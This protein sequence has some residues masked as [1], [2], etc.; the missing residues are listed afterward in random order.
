[1]RSFIPLI[2]SCLTLSLSFHK[3]GTLVPH[4]VHPLRPRDWFML[5]NLELTN[6]DMRA[7]L[8]IDNVD[9]IFKRGRQLSFNPATGADG[10]PVSLSITSTN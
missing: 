5:G 2:Q 9:F 8:M 3:L 7:F 6:E 4:L 1:M 10:W